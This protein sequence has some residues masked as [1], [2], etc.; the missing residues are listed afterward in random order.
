MYS[1]A[2]VGSLP[3]RAWVAD[4]AGLPPES[5]WT[6]TV[7]L[8]AACALTALNLI[9]TL[10]NVASFCPVVKPVAAVRP[11]WTPTPKPSDAALRLLTEPEGMN[12]AAVASRLPVVHVL[13]L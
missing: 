4:A 7:R 9:V 5:A 1:P 10:H 12:C 6:A 11:D 2:P 13:S 8:S 3:V